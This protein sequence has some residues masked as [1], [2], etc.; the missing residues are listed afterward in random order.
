MSQKE[1][2]KENIFKKLS[3]TNVRNLSTCRF[4][5]LE[6]FKL[7]KSKWTLQRKSQLA[8]EQTS[9]GGWWKPWKNG[10]SMSRDKGV[11]FF[12]CLFWLFKQDG[13]KSA[14]R[15]KWNPIS[16]WCWV[17]HKLDSNNTKEVLPLLW[18]FWAPCQASQ[19]RDL[20]KGLGI[21]KK[22]DFEGEQDLTAGLA[23]DWGKQRLYSCRTQTKCCVQ[24]DSGERSNDH[25]GD[26]IRPTS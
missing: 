11:F 3:V 23:Q 8:V 22:S 9:I 21:P 24:Q 20:S 18:R 1:K 2:G 12:V 16:S 14:I 15:T 5:K 4:K 10:Y 6:E 26:W 13:R 25:T 19:S 7:G 17:T